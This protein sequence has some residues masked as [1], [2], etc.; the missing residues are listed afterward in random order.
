[1]EQLC[2]L[3]YDILRP[4]I[5]HINHLETMAELCFILRVEMIDEHV[6]NNRMK[7]FCSRILF[8]V[9]EQINFISSRTAG[10]IS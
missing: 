6:N 3:L 8:R 9:I 4:H 10:R 2:G 5:I 7:L 1:L